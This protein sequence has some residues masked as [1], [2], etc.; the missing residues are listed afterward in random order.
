MRRCPSLVS[1]YLIAACAIAPGARAQATTAKPTSNG[2]QVPV[3]LLAIAG[4][5]AGAF[6]L[7]RRTGQ[8]NNQVQE[9]LR[10]YH[11]I[12]QADETPLSLAVSAEPSAKAEVLSKVAPVA[13]PQM[14]PAPV[15]IAPVET[16]PVETAQTTTVQSA[17]DSAPAVV[18]TP[19][20]ASATHTPDALVLE[21]VT[22][23]GE[24]LPEVKPA[25]PTAATSAIA[26]SAPAPLLETQRLNQGSAI[27]QLIQDLQNPDANQRRRAIWGLSQRGDTRAVQPLVDL[28]ID[29]DS[30]QRSMILSALSEIGTRT[31]KPMSRALAISLQDESPDVRK[32]AIRDLTRVYDL[33][34][35][36]SHMVHQATEDPD[37]DVRETA[38]WALK[39]MNRFRVPEGSSSLKTSVSPPESL[40]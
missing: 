33:M 5:T 38:Q 22:P 23:T 21:A 25:A 39:Q 8:K 7:G 10:D 2:W 29:S 28:M 11:R 12:F 14:Q 35:Q 32:N 37:S 1:L 4:G 26:P 31:L 16:A 20:S 34:A 40:T 18:H 19:A 36:I 6:Y 3:G 27:D 15:E 17:V 24:T 13:E 30:K 9:T